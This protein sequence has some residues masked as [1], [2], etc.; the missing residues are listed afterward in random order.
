LGLTA[1]VVIVEVDRE[2]RDEVLSEVPVQKTIEQ[3]M[4]LPLFKKKEGQKQFRLFV[5]MAHFQYNPNS[6][7]LETVV[8]PAPFLVSLSSFYIVFLEKKKIGHGFKSRIN[9]SYF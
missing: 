7:L 4:D 8:R 1:A 9:K 3:K 2:E 6:R 5:K